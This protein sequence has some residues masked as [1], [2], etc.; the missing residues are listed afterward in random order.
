M[1]ITSQPSQTPSL[2]NSL[3]GLVAVATFA[4]PATA[5]TTNTW[6]R[7]ESSGGDWNVISHWSGGVVPDATT[8]AYFN[9][10]EFGS[11]SRVTTI[12]YSTSLPGHDIGIRNVGAVSLLA[13]DTW[14]RIIRGT[15]NSVSGEGMLVLHGVQA[16]LGGETVNLLVANHTSGQ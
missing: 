3:L 1:K 13:T 9:M 16:D 5:Q 4:L 2:R 8:H 12:N 6:I 14:G 15:D 7:A 10:T 11:L